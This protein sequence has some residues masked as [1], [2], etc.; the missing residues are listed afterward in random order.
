MRKYWPA[1]IAFPFLTVALTAHS[2]QPPPTT[3]APQ[4]QGAGQAPPATQGRGGRGTQTPEQREAAAKEAY[5]REAALPR[6]IPARDSVWIEELTYLEV[7]DAIKAGK[8]TALVMTGSTEQ[9][10][11][12]MS[13]GKHQYAMKLVGEATARK[14]GNALIAPLIPIEVGNPDNKY[15]EW[16]SLYFTA[17]TFQAVVRDVATSLKSQ[18]FK[19]IVLLGD[20]GGNTA[21]LRAVAAE[22]APK[23][24]DTARIVHVP[25][26]YNWTNQGGVRDFV[27][28]TLGIPEK[29]SEG[30]HDEYG[31]SAVMM[32]YDPKL[33]RFDERVAA[34]KAT[35]NSISLEPKAKTIDNGKKIVE[36][37]ANV[38]VEAIKKAL[39]GSAPAPQAAA[40]QA[41]APQAAAPAAG[42]NP[43]YGNWRL[44]PT[45]PQ[46]PPSTNVMTYEPFNGTGMKVTINR[47]NPDGS[48]T[49]QWGYDT[50]LDGKE[51]PMTGSSAG[52]M[53]SVRMI[54]DRVAEI[55]YRRDGRILRQLTN[56]ISPDGN[57]LGIIYM[58]Y[59]VD[60]KPDTVTFAT[61]ERMK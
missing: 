23:W 60:G 59:G 38:A 36:F 49:A 7:R 24:G 50:M 51:M 57:L 34:R 14:L 10:G 21:G 35:I 11:P 44:K 13:G 27:I 3:A 20:S 15:L 43:R 28:N 61:Y 8:T 17:E 6:P 46:A 42:T 12:Y 4:G 56:V 55:T 53:A 47:L 29:Q 39:S 5:D 58:N 52:Q 41:S 45:D 1:L 25:E 37:R 54:S 33:I 19:N 48:L 26:Y 31:L 9:N 32:A 40:P 30:V 18:G 22:L 16:G 2:Q